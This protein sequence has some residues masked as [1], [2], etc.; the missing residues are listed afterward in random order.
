[1]FRHLCGDL[2]HQRCSAWSLMHRIDLTRSRQPADRTS[3]RWQKLHDENQNSP[4]GVA[5]AGG[6]DVRLLQQPGARLR[7]HQQPCKRPQLRP[8][9][10]HLL[11]NTLACPFM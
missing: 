5:G 2:C 8:Q 11:T 9:E 3:N 1:M 6:G 4:V 10:A 7:P